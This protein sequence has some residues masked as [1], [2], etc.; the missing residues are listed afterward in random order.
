MKIIASYP[1]KSWKIEGEKVKA[2]TDFILL[3]SK[4]TADGDCSH[5]MKLKVTQRDGMGREVGEG[6][7]MGSTRRPM[8]DSYQC[9]AKTTTIL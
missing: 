2:V 7:R 1:I 9:V 3:G 8:A 4:I 5:E 6:F